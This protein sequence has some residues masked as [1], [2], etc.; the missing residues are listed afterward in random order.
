MAEV[1]GAGT[2]CA[3]PSHKRTPFPL[4]NHRALSSQQVPA[5][6]VSDEVAVASPSAT[7]IFTWL[8][9][10]EELLVLHC[11]QSQGLIFLGLGCDFFVLLSF[12]LFSGGGLQ[13]WYKMI[14]A[15]MG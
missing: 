2:G 9:H 7:D 6:P 1:A 14:T 10:G 11:L 15:C 3:V 13:Q 8:W 12:W 4:M 5:P